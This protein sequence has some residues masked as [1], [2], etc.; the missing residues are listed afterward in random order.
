MLALYPMI[1]SRS[2]RFTLMLTT[3]SRK[4]RRHC[5]LCIVIIGTSTI[6]RRYGTPLLMS[7]GI[8]RWSIMHWCFSNIIDC[9]TTI[10]WFTTPCSR[11]INVL[12][13]FLNINSINCNLLTFSCHFNNALFIIS[14][15]YST[16]LSFPYSSDD[17]YSLA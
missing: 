4:S 9:L 5:S 3:W 10:Y 14:S 13:E 11:F 12:L 6:G 16:S 17:L 15:N 7:W 1:R 8:I 2:S